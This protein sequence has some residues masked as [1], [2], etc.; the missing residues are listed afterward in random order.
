MI[1]IVYLKNE[2]LTQIQKN[3]CV[4]LWRCLDSVELWKNKCLKMEENV[5]SATK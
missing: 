5:D 3:N 4:L 2:D 1:T